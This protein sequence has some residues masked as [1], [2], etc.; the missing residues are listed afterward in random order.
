MSAITETQIV[1]GGTRDS[2]I[3]FAREL[4]HEAKERIVS[5]A[6]STALCSARPLANARI[7]EY[8]LLRRANA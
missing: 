1:K 3:G 4:H 8:R 5:E 6:D 7:L 2:E